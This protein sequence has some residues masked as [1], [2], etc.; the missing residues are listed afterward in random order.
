MLAPA[1]GALTALP[2]AERERLLD[3]IWSSHLEDLLKH[4][5]LDEPYTQD[6]LR[7]AATASSGGSLELTMLSGSSVT[8][9]ADSINGELFVDGGLFFQPANL[10]GVDG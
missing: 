10:R 4:W 8:I 7:Q 2:L 3:P 9:T 5:L 6:E 1:D